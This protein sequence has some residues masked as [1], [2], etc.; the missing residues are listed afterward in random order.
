MKFIGAGRQVL[1]GGLTVISIHVVP[2]AIIPLQLVGVITLLLVLIGQE[3]KFHREFPYVGRNCDLSG[4]KGWFGRYSALL[5]GVEPFV[6][7]IVDL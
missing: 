4:G 2:V 3:C 7:T 5:N 1:I 6:R